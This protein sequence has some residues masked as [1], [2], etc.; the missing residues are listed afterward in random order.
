MRKL[1]IVIAMLMLSMSVLAQQKIVTGIV[2]NKTTS[3]PLEG[4]TVQVKNTAVVTDA[5]GNFSIQASPG[6]VI[7]VSYVGMNSQ[8]IKVTKATETFNVALEEGNGGMEQVVVTG[9]K[10]ERKKD[11][12]GA[13]SIV[14]INETTKE[15]NINILTSLQGRVPGV[16]ISNDG[17][18]GGTG[19]AVTIRGF[20]TT[21]ST[22][23]L[24]VI[25]GV[26]TTNAGA[27][28]QADIESIQVLKDAASATIYGAR[29]NNGV[30]IIT[31]KKG[32]SPKAEVS[33]NSFVGVQQVAHQLHFLNTQQYGEAVWQAY[34]YS[35]LAPTHSVYGNG[36]TPVAAPFIDPNK[37]MPTANTDWLDAIFRKS[38]IQSYNVGLNKASDKSSFYLGLNYD[39]DNGIQQYSDY[40]KFNTRLNS[41]FNLNKILVGENLQVTNFRQLNFGTKAM[42]DAVFQF[43]YIPVYDIN[44]NFGGPWAGDQ[45]DKRNPLGELYNNRNNRSKQWRIFGNIYG[46]A[47]PLKGLTFRTSL[48]IDYTN[49]YVRSFAPTY[50]EGS[51]GNP[52]A[53]LNTTNRFNL[54]YVW[55]NTLNYRLTVSNHVFELLG[56]VEA[57]RNHQES[58][59]ASN[60]GFISNDY[61]YTY[62]GTAT[63]A[64]TAAGSASQNSLFSQFGKL[65]YSYLDKY[66]I[67]ATVRRDGSSRFGETNRYGV[68]PAFSAGWRINRENFLSGVNNI[69]DLK[70]RGSWGQTGNQEIGDYATV[71]LY[72]T[73]ADFSNY[74]LVGTPTGAQAGYYASQLGNPNLKWESQ[75]Q[76]DIGAD[77]LGFNNHITA[78]VDWYNK[79]TSNLL[80]NPA[81]LAVVGGAT[82]P[83]VNS[84]RVENKGWEFQLGYQNP[85][86]A[87]LHWNADF[88]IAFNHNK[89]LALTENVPY[90]T[91]TYG[92]VEPGHAMNEFFGYIADGIFHTQKEVDDYLSSVKTGDFKAAPGRIRYRDLNGNGAIDA[93]DRTYIG[94]PF[95]KLNY[96]FNLSA[97]MMGFDASVF[98]AGVSGNKIFNEDKKYSQ[99]GLFASNYSTTVL[100]AWTP[101]NSSSNIA[102]LQKTLTN[103]EGRT[104][105][106][107][108]EDGSYLKFK[109][110]QVG[111]TLPKSLLAKAR[112]N[113]LRFYVQGENLFTFTKYT[114][115]DPESVSTGPLNKGV[116][117]Q[118]SL[119][120]HAKSVNFGV[121]L[122]F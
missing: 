107:F 62:L 50:I 35:G 3:E 61:N 104:S 115:M 31:T 109:S 91:T 71:D 92:R 23:P 67:S 27:L 16:A 76:T 2:T 97:N 13:V 78:S 43:P 37:T 99:L 44:G 6:E 74:N 45:S 24:Y 5:R 36:T 70:I 15:S 26:A 82:A 57:V 39:R 108:V 41:S 69:N 49:F 79:Q 29:A 101:S 85:S 75:T 51:H 98:L 105:T 63:G 17:T 4:V 116:D 72:R 93:N 47:Y 103:N 119:Y 64:S 90:I 102:A 21:G 10:T 53:S 106:Y 55:T 14:N 117:F 20:S 60:T 73:N 25:D 121:N 111:Y 120:P 40:D 28:T 65:N 38:T 30:I 56:G 118:G 87:K 46:E 83:F 94:S 33:F 122:N 89:V 8:S 1:H 95:P 66:L 11:I 19:F 7:T 12:T 59:N 113:N 54:N 58:F 48:G 22:G 9:Y 112:I 18:P 100:D 68:F 110:I 84:G 34:K 114:G 81:L 52:T 42:N 96:G 86:N 88:N 32:R 77:F 80:I